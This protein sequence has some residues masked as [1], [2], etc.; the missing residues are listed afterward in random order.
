M[1]SQSAGSGPQELLQQYGNNPALMDEGSINV[2]PNADD[3]AK[4]FFRMNEE[5]TQTDDDVP[6]AGAGHI[7]DGWTHPELVLPPPASEM[8]SFQDPSDH[9]AVYD[10]SDYTRTPGAVETVENARASISALKNQIES[11]HAEAE[12]AKQVYEAEKSKS[13]Q[14]EAEYLKYVQSMQQA[15]RQ[16]GRRNNARGGLSMWAP[17]ASAPNFDN[18]QAQPPTAAPQSDQF[19]IDP[20]TADPAA[21]YR[22]QFYSES[23]PAQPT[24]AQDG[25]QPAVAQQATQQSLMAFEPV[26]SNGQGGRRAA[27]LSAE[28]QEVRDRSVRAELAQDVA[29]LQLARQRLAAAI[30]RPSALKTEPLQVR[31]FC[32]EGTP[33]CGEEAARPEQ[34]AY[35]GRAVGAESERAMQTAGDKE[36]PLGQAVREEPHWIGD[37]FMH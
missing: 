16:Y 37:A 17:H 2:D 4:E 30:T 6:D 24:L 22:K 11:A 26:E 3:A 21:M 13:Q 35:Y 36:V 9:A 23:A 32:P 19:V 31:E 29:R 27:L 28:E 7:L 20:S 33:G 1:I 15:R 25:A 10:P 5:S 8:E 18:Q 12:D 14:L 34:R